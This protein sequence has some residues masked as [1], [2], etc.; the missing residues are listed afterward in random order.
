MLVFRK[1]CPLRRPV[2]GS[3]ERRPLPASIR[4]NGR[5]RGD[6]LLEERWTIWTRGPR[7]RFDAATLLRLLRV[8]VEPPHSSE[9]DDA[10]T[11]PCPLEMVGNET[12]MT[13]VGLVLAAEQARP[14]DHHVSQS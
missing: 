10:H 1:H 12:A 8:L 4:V 3:S 7:I 9:V 2:E 13:L 14:I 11:L 5:A 6:S